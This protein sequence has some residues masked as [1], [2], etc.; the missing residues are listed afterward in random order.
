LVLPTVAQASCDAA[1]NPVAPSLTLPAGSLITYSQSAA[2]AA[3][4]TVT[5]TATVKDAAKYDFTKPI[6]PWTA[7]AAGVA[8]YDVVFAAAPACPAVGGVGAG[9]TTVSPVAPSFGDP[10]CGTSGATAP[11]VTT[12]STPAG[13]TYTVSPAGPYTGGETVTVTA[14]ITDPSEQ[15]TAPGTGG[16]TFVDATHETITHTFAAAPT[17]SGVGGL[18][19]VSAHPTFTEATCDDG[20]VYGASYTL[21][22]VDGVRYVVDGR[23][24]VAGTYAAASGSTID[25]R[26]AATHG[27][28]LRDDSPI[29][30]TFADA[31]TC[32]GVEPASTPGQPLADTGARVVPLTE[33]GGLLIILGAALVLGGRRRSRKAL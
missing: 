4:T 33:L 12:P 10:A 14:T 23:H 31:P 20:T 6:A 3:G 13:V 17:C 7:G 24:R 11:F 5:V 22:D 26:L 21:P 27:F 25:V 32:H 15:F 8:T 19:A 9:P 1:G 29:V 2:A 30:H 18:K 16:W 28:T